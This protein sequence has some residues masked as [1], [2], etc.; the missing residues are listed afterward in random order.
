MKNQSLFFLAVGMGSSSIKVLL[1][2]EIWN[3]CH[4]LLLVDRNWPCRAVAAA[5][6]S[7]GHGIIGRRN[8]Q[9]YM[10][11]LSTGKKLGNL[12]T[13]KGKFY[14]SSLLIYTNIRD[15]EPL[16][17]LQVMMLL[18]VFFQF[19]NIVIFNYHL[20]ILSYKNSVPIL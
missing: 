16:M 13:I 20:H 12:R 6:T 15:V 7:A 2:L 18:F 4:V 8:G 17:I 1:S 5:A 19:T 11:E 9:V 10:L 3:Q 14:C